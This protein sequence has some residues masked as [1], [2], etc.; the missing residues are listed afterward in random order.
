MAIVSPE[1]IIYRIVTGPLKGRTC[2]ISEKCDDCLI[3]FLADSERGERARVLPGCL[4]ELETPGWTE[5]DRFYE[6]YGLE[7]YFKRHEGDGSNM[8][9]APGVAQPQA[10]F[11]GD[12]LATGQCIIGVPRRGS[13]SSVLV[14][15]DAFG[16]VELASRLPVALKGNGRYKLPIELAEG[17]TLVTGC[18]VFKMSYATKVN[19]VTIVLDKADGKIE[20]PS[21]VP[22]ALA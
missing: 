13:N 14:R 7:E 8:L 3:V 12:K 19:W 5:T 17:D 2:T 4:A 21:C 6:P 15:I 16:W 20:V 18:R 11:P 10:L 9:R 1:S 22:L